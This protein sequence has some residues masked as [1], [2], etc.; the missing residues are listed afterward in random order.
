MCSL[1]MLFLT[2]VLNHNV[3]SVTDVTVMTTATKLYVFKDS[4]KNLPGL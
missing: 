4:K 2:E 1:N 3:L